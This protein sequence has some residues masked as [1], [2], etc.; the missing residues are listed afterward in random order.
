MGRADRW[1]RT[2]VWIAAWNGR[3]EI[4]KF[5]A[6]K[7]DLNQADKIGD[8]PVHIAAW[9]GHTEIVKFLADKVHLNRANR[10]GYTPVHNAAKEG[11][12]E[13]V[14]F[15]I[16]KKVK[17]EENVLKIA[18]TEEIKQIIAQTLKQWAGM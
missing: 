7:V 8:T 4:V 17:L 3:T 15:L 1:G 13:V 12:I 6:D 18:A 9:K 10:Y 2:F 11:R 16:A 14:K 5:L